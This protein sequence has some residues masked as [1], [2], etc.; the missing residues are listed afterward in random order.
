MGIEVFIIQEEIEAGKEINIPENARYFRKTGGNINFFASKNRS[1][2]I[3]RIPKGSKIICFP[4]YRRHCCHINYG[5]HYF[6]K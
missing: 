3:I 6:Q 2:D 1:K 5:A 4:E